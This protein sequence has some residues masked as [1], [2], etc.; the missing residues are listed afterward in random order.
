LIVAEKSNFEPLKCR[1]EFHRDESMRDIKTRQSQFLDRKIDS[2][3]TSNP[4][5]DIKKKKKQFSACELT[6]GNQENANSKRPSKVEPRKIIKTSKVEQEGGRRRRK[7]ASA[8]HIQY[9]Q[10]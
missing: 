1:L 4:H 9:H 3:S 8:E 6:S 2:Q 10:Q 5:E 7:R